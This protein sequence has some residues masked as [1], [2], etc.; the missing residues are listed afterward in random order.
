MTEQ[1]SGGGGCLPKGGQVLELPEGMLP[2]PLSALASIL[3]CLVA[4]GPGTGPPVFNH[5]SN[6]RWGQTTQ[7][8]CSSY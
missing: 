7:W 5:M 4:T 2:T 6:L 8:L 3:S 1:H